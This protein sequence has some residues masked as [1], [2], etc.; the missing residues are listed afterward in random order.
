MLKK[1]LSFVLT[2]LLI[3]TINVGPVMAL[4]TLGDQPPPIETIKE[5]ITKR[6]VGEKARVSVRLLSGT[7]LKGYIS[8]AG[9]D[10]FVITDAKTKQATT[11]AYRDVE[12]VKGKGLSTGAK[13]GIGAGIAAAALA[14]GYSTA[15]AACGGLCEK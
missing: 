6:G 7:K 5:K 2:G 15:R 14:I 10:T 13:I 8:D 9:E 12:Q 3:S 1:C 11:V 4:T